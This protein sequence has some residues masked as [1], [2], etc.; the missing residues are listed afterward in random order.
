MQN[1]RIK[2]SIF[3][4]SFLA[5]F[6]IRAFEGSPARANTTAP[7]S[8]ATGAPGEQSCAS[9]H[10]GAAVNSGGGAMTL[11]GLPASYAPNQQIA[12]ALTLTQAARLQFGFEI[13]AVDDAGRQAGTLIVTNTNRTILSTGTVSSNTRQYIGQTLA[14]SVPT[15]G[16]VGSWTFSW[17]APAQSVGRVTFYVAGLA[18]NNSGNTS[19]DSVYTLAQ[20]IQSGNAPPLTAL[21]NTSAASF[22]PNSALASQS[23]AA[24]FG[25]GLAQT[26][27]S[28]TASPLPTQ[29]GGAE[30]RVRDAAGAERSAGLF[31]VSPGQINYLMPPG[32]ANG[33]A[34]VTVLRNGAA[35]AQGSVTIDTIAPGLFSANA[36]GIGV[37]AA[38]ILRVRGGVSTFEP[39]AQ[40]NP[41]TQRFV[42]APID[43][44]PQTDQVFLVVFG[45]GFRNNTTLSAATA[46]I[47]GAGASVLFAGAQ[48][49]LAGLDQ[50]NILLPRSLAGRG[51][52]DVVFSVA[53]KSANT[54][55]INIR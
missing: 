51:P 3:L 27:A 13:T 20:S 34:T 43:L 1:R 32:T 22:A 30:V 45:S 17:R 14:G 4:L 5:A 11:T 6:V 8:G 38:V 7:P 15:G 35:A 24:G 9:C 37:P 2:L 25:A 19:G 12:L 29:L 55:Q 46:T 41:Q 47:G 53:G 48:G 18:G 54:M 50:A 16:D 33:A 10:G 28:A 36:D 49:A 26:T 52:V 23:I 42:P 39:V 31:F 21:A 44:G 40:R